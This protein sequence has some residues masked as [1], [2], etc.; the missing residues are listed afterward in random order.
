[1]KTRILLPL[2]TLLLIAG[3]LLYSLVLET[4][5]PAVVPHERGNGSSEEVENISAPDSEGAGRSEAAVGLFHA[6]DN[7]I[8]APV[9]LFTEVLPGSDSRIVV[10]VDLPDGMQA[11]DFVLQQRWRNT[12]TREVIDSYGAP[13]KEVDGVRF[14]HFA[15]IGQSVHLEL[16]SWDELWRSGETV[17]AQTGEPE[18]LTCR[19]ARTAVVDVYAKESGGRAL[20]EWRLDIESLSPHSGRAT[21]VVQENDEVSTFRWPIEIESIMDGVGRRVTRLLAGPYRIAAGSIRHVM[22]EREVILNGGQR[23]A[24]HFQLVMLP[25]GGDMAGVVRRLSGARKD[26]EGTALVSD[27]VLVQNIEVPELEFRAPLTWTSQAGRFAG[28]WRVEDVPVGTY[29]V[30][31]ISEGWVGIEPAELQVVPPSE[32]L[33]FVVRDVAGFKDIGFDAVS[34]KTGEPI[35]EARVV[36]HLTHGGTSQSLATP[37]SITRWN[38]P[39]DSP[40][41][42]DLTATGYHARSGTIA[43]FNEMR[44]FAGSAAWIARVALTPL[45]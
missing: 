5:E 6:P 38:V 11:H 36:F 30:R 41:S 33:E 19:L 25:I 14:A 18:S 35:A 20:P 10:H 16:Q 42:W 12:Q 34:A 8:G 4:D 1:V 9:D 17:R 26:P 21:E 23:E 28:R 39:V 22:Q 31:P 29:H 37:D 15:R 2:L 40:V 3:G 13:L 27:E 43:D 45:E 7:S 32:H 44:A 24:Q